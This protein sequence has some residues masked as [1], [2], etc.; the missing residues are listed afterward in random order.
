M[1]KR[2]NRFLKTEKRLNVSFGR[3]SDS[4]SSCGSVLKGKFRIFSWLTWMKKSRTYHSRSPRAADLGHNL[5][6]TVFSSTCSVHR[7]TSPPKIWNSSWLILNSSKNIPIHTHLF[8]LRF[9]ESHSHPRLVF[10]YALPSPVRTASTFPSA[11]PIPESAIQIPCI[12]VRN[13]QI[14]TAIDQLIIF[15]PSAST[16]NLHGKTVLR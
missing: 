13:N 9:A 15:L 16:P 2:T 7:Q 3:L 6:S 12:H 11:P 1:P 5:E 4:C 14:I 8:R 10:I